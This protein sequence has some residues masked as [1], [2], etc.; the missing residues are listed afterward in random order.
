M[1]MSFVVGDRIVIV[2][3]EEKIERIQQADPFELDMRKMG[4]TTLAIPFKIFIC[5]ARKDD[6]RLE[7]LIRKQDID[8]MLNYLAR[9]FRVTASDHD[10]GY[11]LYA[12]MKRE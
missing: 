5:Y 8:G 1:A 9:G 11:D 3:D 6:A 12:K 7:E 4:T 10:R 2:L